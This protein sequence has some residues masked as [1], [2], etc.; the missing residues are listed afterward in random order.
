MVSK[1]KF[2]TNIIKG[3]IIRKRIKLN[4]NVLLTENRDD[5]RYMVDF[6]REVIEKGADPKKTIFYQFISDI[7]KNFYYQP[8]KTVKE[9]LDLYKKSA[10]EGIKGKIPIMGF[11]DPFVKTRW[12]FCGNSFIKYIRNTTGY[13]LYDD[14]SY[15]IYNDNTLRYV[16]PKTKLS[17][18][19]AYKLAIA[20]YLKYKS[21]PCVLLE[22]DEENYYA[23]NCTEFIKEKKDI[24]KFLIN[25][26]KLRNFCHE[27][28]AIYMKRL[29]IKTDGSDK[30][31][32]Y[33]SFKKLKINGARDTEKRFKIYSLDKLLTK[34][35]DVLDIGS[36][37]G[38][39]SL[40]CSKYV[41]SIDGIEPNKS[42]VE[43]SNYTKKF[44]GITN[45]NFYETT[46]EKFKTKKKYD[47]VFS[48]AVHRYMKTSLEEYLRRIY[49][50]L[51]KEGFLL[52]E[53]H[54][55]KKFY[56]GW[57]TNC[58]STLYSAEELSF[59]KTV[60]DLVDKGLFKIVNYGFSYDGGENFNSKRMFYLLK[61]I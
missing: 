26:D 47:I 29:K 61:K 48:F 52:L 25:D 46:I 30:I 39:F 37:P 43:V 17:Q 15:V 38:F 9:F 1:I 36:N 42:C 59:T 60:N 14:A 8:N 33:Q 20:I 35:H 49:D 57:F 27:L 11:K 4:P 28:N 16:I 10:K 5:I 21:I 2:I 34:K 13:Q 51:K 22:F 54:T 19:A 44:L 53:S 32:F 55:I 12:F 50:L 24:Y 58:I 3:K 40:Y 31:C 41:N 56:S 45:C 18:Q 23:L 7:D 6:L